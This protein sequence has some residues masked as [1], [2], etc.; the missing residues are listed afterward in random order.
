MMMQVA[1]DA[2][3]TASLDRMSKNTRCAYQKDLS[4]L[5]QY[6]QAQ[7][8]EDWSLVTA[9]QIT[10]YLAEELCETHGYRQSTI[11]R[12]FAAMKSFFRYLCR[13]GIIPLNPTEKVASPGIGLHQKKEVPQLLLTEQVDCLFEQIDKQTPG[14]LRD[15]ALLHIILCTGLLASELLSLDLSDVHSADR[16]VLLRG[17]VLPLSTMAAEALLQYQEQGRPLLVQDQNEQ[18]LFI[19]QR[20]GQRLSRAGF[21]LIVKGYE[22]KVGVTITPRLLRQT[23]VVRMLNAGMDISAAQQLL[24]ITTV[25]HIRK[26]IAATTRLE[27]AEEGGIQQ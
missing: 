27:Q 8:V 1:I 22:R 5:C 3:T 21:W 9:E 13:N 10:A 4:Q 26:Y 14:G 6:L 25:A 24:G 18:A 19:N 16:T 11:T 7:G 12:K 2:Y 23:C 20:N 17:R 15:C